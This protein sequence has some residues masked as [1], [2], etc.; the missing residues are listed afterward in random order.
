MKIKFN[1]KKYFNFVAI[2]SVSAIL[3][4]ETVYLQKQLLEAEEKTKTI[5]QYLQKEQVDKININTLK[6]APSFGFN[7]L[8]ADWNWLQF[9]NYFGDGEAREKIGYSLCPDFLES[10][11][12][13]DPR[14]VRAYFLLAPA[15]SI[16]AGEPERNVQAI[17]KGLKS[18]TPDLSPEGYYLWVYKGID[19]MMFLNDIEAAKKSY[20]TASAW[21]EQST[22]PGAKQSAINTRQTAEFLE[23]DPDSLV[24]QIGAWTMVLSSTN[25]TRTQQK[26]L[27]KIEGLGGEI[28]VLPD[29]GV[30][31]RVPENAT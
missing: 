29:G 5:A 17:S 25:D 26:A 13:H 3:L 24:A 1:S 2:L 27:E 19:E 22:H 15:T 6:K 12:N 16:F 9:L 10:I 20:R 31:I 11:V 21:A 30:R 18:I 8:I 14:F 4:C 7:N 23:N 28:I